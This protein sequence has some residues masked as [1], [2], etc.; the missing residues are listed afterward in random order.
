MTGSR[1]WRRCV[2]AFAVAGLLALSGCVEVDGEVGA[3]GSLSLR[4]TYVPPRHS[5][6]KSETARL[7]S[8]HV[9]VKGIERDRSIEGHTNGVYVTATLAVDDAKQL[10]TAAAFERVAVELDQAAR[11]LRIILPGFD[12]ATRERLLKG[13]E[14]GALDQR[15]L[16]LSLLLPGP[17]EVTEPAATPAAT[18]DGRR[19]TW[20][21]SIRQWAEAGE[22]VTLT[23]SWAGS[24]PIQ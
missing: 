6:F 17:V 11:R 5:T 18:I 16:R 15:A 21:L 3:D 22:K 9:R 13:S 8:A 1:A 23:A 2:A 7:G 14:S 12:A 19:V 20:T 10:S 24:T 4:C